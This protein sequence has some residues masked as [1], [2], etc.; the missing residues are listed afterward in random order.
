[1]GGT[2]NTPRPGVAVREAGL[3]QQDRQ[4]L[5]AGSSSTTRPLGRVVAGSA[6]LLPAMGIMAGSRILGFFFVYAGGDRKSVV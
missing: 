5:L 3:P 6:R 2:W 1:V 4:P